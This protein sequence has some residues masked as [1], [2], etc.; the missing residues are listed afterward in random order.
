M[1]DPNLPEVVSRAE[2]LAARRALLEREKAHTRATDALNAERRRLPMVAVERDYRLTGPDGEIGLLDVFAG[3]RQLVVYHAM[4]LYPEGRLCPSCAG[5]LDEIGH[6]AHLN[7]RDTTFAAITRGPF[8]E[9]ERWQA[10]LGWSFPWYSSAGSDFNFDFH[11]T[12]DERVRPFEYNYA[13]RAELAAKGLPV[14]E[15]EQ[16]FDLHGLS[17]FLR[18][19]DRVFHT[20]SA[21]ARGTDALGL[22]TGFLDRTA[23]GRQEPWEQPE[24]RAT[25]FGA[26]AGSDGVRYHDEYP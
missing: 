14:D 18:V 21:Y 15:W 13:S 20:Y 9:L 17:A 22:T 11:V 12:L 24:G 10:R 6:L 23:L 4:W 7:A 8:A 26:P 16:P 1:T 19:D 5:F 2:W 25:A 3:R